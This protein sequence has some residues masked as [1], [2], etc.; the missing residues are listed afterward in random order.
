MKKWLSVLLALAL[1]LGCLLPATAEQKVD[2]TGKLVI[3]HTNEVHGYAVTG[4]TPPSVGYA[5]IKQYKLDAAALGASVL[6]LDAGDVS[7]GQPI[8]NL[9]M[10][11][12][13]YQFMY[14]VWYDAMCPGNHEF[15]WGVDQM[16]HNA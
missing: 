1:T 16:L 15:D 10:G 12:T 14:A 8:V 5:Q 7:Q 6:L 9:S 11:A 4:G 13:A 2:L 3:V